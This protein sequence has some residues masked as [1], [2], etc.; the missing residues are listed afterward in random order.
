M[1]AVR[2]GIIGGGLMGRAFAGAIA[3]TCDLAE[4]FVRVELLGV[5]SRTAGSLDWFT[6]RFSRLKVATTDYRELLSMSDLDAVY[7]AVPNHLHH[8]VYC[9]VLC[10]GKHLFG[11]KPF[12]IDLDANK[13]ILA[14]VDEHPGLVARCSSEYPFVPA[15]QRIGA[16]IEHDAFGTV[17]EVNA[18]FKHSSDL[19]PNKQINWKRRR[20][21][22]GTYGVMGDLG[23]HICHMPFRAGWRPM[24]VRAILSNVVT[25]RPDAD[26]NHV[27]CDTWD[28]AT[29]LCRA[30]DRS[31]DSLFP[32]TLKMQRICP[33]ETNTWELEILGTR[34][35]V[36]FSTKNINMLQLLE[37]DGGDQEW[38][39]ID[40][41]YR[42][43]FKTGIGT[44]F[45][46]GFSDAMLQMLASFVHEVDHGESP[47]GFGGCVTPDE[48]ALSHRL[49][50]AAIE[51]HETG[52]VRPV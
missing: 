46:F 10:A 5:A 7:V 22:N 3:R 14:C 8:Q 28:N 32:L 34:A 43:L 25:T 19:N 16:L 41:G 18:S 47:A 40:I 11:E 36:R 2:F 27:A 42:P 15:V 26:G 35:S 37:Y 6:R 9:D 50:S 1:K 52:A 38:R 4:P 12:G 48:T 49:F 29:L 21:S 24:D 23:M 17:L 30:S 44:I 39:N 20:E 45:E 31:G 13:A 33:G 51:S